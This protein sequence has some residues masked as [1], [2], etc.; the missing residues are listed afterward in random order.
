MPAR[1]TARKPDKADRPSK[2]WPR[3]GPPQ[4]FLL[5]DELVQD[6]IRHTLVEQ[7]TATILPSLREEMAKHVASIM[8]QS[9]NTISPHP[10]QGVNLP[11]APAVA[12]IE[13]KRKHLGHLSSLIRKQHEAYVEAVV[14]L[15]QTSP[16]DQSYRDVLNAAEDA[17]HSYL[18]TAQ[19]YL[20]AMRN[21]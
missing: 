17:T 3:V 14:R 13:A 9:E 16:M 12:P 15:S 1:K 8:R 20:D 18:D 7:L 5:T 2:R 4:G 19:L 21:V 6:D 10:G 11:P